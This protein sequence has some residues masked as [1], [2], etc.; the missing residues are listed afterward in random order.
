MEGGGRPQSVQYGKYVPPWVASHYLIQ[1]N[2]KIPKGNWRE[3]IWIFSLN[4]S[5]I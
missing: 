2:L 1:K 3:E 4:T 5:L